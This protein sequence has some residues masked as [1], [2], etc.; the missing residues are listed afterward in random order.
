MTSYPLPTLGPTISAAGIS[1]PAFA[2]ILGSLQFSYQSLYG[3][4][5]DL[6][7]DTQDGQ[8][9]GVLASAIND[10]NSAIIASFNARSPSTAQGVG[11]SSVVKINGLTRQVQT[12]STAPVTLIGI[13]GTVINNGLIGDNV[14]LG[15]Q[16]TIPP[17]T[18]IGDGGTVT[19]TT[20]CTTPGA[21]TAEA[22]TLTNILTPTL[23]WQSV[24]N[25]DSA[26]PGAPIEDDAQ[27]RQRQAQSQ[28]QAAQSPAG[29]TLGAIL[30]LAG[31][32]RATYDENTG[33]GAD[34]NGVPGKSICFIVG[35][36]DVGQIAAT[37][38]QKKSIGCGTYGSTSEVIIDPAGNPITISFDVLE[39]T[40]VPTVIT[41]SAGPTYSDITGALIQAAV[42]AY[43][44]GLPIGAP[45]YLAKV[46]AIAALMTSS[47]NTTF[48]VT[49]ITLNGV[50][51]D[52]DVAFN[53]AAVAL[54]TDITITVGP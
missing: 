15:T 22:D 41:I 38:V 49:G 40:T 39:L 54:T 43:I 17:F 46:S 20:T 3:Q 6:D 25:D 2:D 29:A 31:V 51:A 37:I 5:A 27:L 48:D 19:V 1:A 36:G 23:G 42:S 30:N 14:G 32:E 44:S 24:N 50:A 12:N 9:L 8:F 18:N 21:I 26:F 7:P 35:G 34:I 47:L 16:W 28:N 10:S 33:S 53:K 11:L 52:F 13:T 4:D 45:V